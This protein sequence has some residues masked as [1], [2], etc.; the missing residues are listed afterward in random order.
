[1]E[2]LSTLNSEPLWT[3]THPATSVWIKH[4]NSDDCY[5]MNKSSTVH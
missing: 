1:M 4:I 3:Q 2:M 5:S